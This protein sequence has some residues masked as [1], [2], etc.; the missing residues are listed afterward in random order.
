MKKHLVGTFRGNEIVTKDGVH[1][2]ADTGETTASTYRQRPCGHCGLHYTKEG[3]DG[4]LGTIP[5]V[6]NACCG[7]GEVSSAYV[8]LSD[9]SRLSGA[10]AAMFIAALEFEL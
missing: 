5:N 6:Q 9:G 7:H 8:V 1:C 4:C 3:H 10:D 2:Y